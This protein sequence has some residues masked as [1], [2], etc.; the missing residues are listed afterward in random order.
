LITELFIVPAVGIGYIV[1]NYHD[2]EGVMPDIVDT[3]DAQF[4][5]DVSEAGKLVIVDMW[6]EWCGP[7]RM[8]EPVLEEISKE[9]AQNVKVVKLNIDKNQD[10]AVKFGVNSIPTFLFFKGGKEV[11]RVVGAFPKKQ[12]AKKVD[13]HLAN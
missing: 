10:T 8:M 5:K 2:W 7:C 13:A 4:E 11:D 9:Y 3:T 1:R 6:A 12:F